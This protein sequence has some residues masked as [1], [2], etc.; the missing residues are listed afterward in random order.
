[1]IAS[2]HALSSRRDS[3]TQDL[4]FTSV[5]IE[6]FRG[7]K[8]AE[9]KNLGRI[10]IVVGDNGSGKTALLEALFLTCGSA[11]S[12][13]FRLDA[14][15]GLYPNAGETISV[16]ISPEDVRSGATW[17]D[18]FWRFD[19]SNTIRVQV[20]GSPGRT[21]SIEPRRSSDSFGSGPL[22]AP[23]KFVWTPDKGK[24]FESVP[25]FV[26][27]TVNFPNAPP[28]L[29]G[30]FI[31]TA[32]VTASESAER[33]SRLSQTRSAEL[34]IETLRA[35][36]EGLQNISLQIAPGSPR[37]ILFADL[38]S[39]SPMLPLP[40]LSSGLNR[41]VAILAGIAT[42]PKGAIFVDEVDTGVHAARLPSL[43]AS[44]V[45]CAR[46]VDAQLFASTHSLECLQA[47]LPLVE[48]APE[49]FRVIRC[50]RG[51]SIEVFGGDGLAAAL[52]GSVEIR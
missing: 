26:K 12:D 49:D 19:L 42:F 47:A 28:G 35:Q 41:W 34:V 11:P 14:W 38:G 8:S 36:F 50:R 4:M 40:L 16:N 52:A 21:F 29:P 44:L 6:N 7:F 30:M 39:E 37:P 2:L 3:V 33:F 18:L 31:S 13:S 25:E 48:A 32:P 43:W 23:F 5:K 27:G 1:M 9:A 24:A 15:R 20:K 10:N 17:A 46:N 45:Q 22:R 51:G